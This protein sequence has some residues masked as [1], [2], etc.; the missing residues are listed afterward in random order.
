MS[1]HATRQRVRL[2]ATGLLSLGLVACVAPPAP[3]YQPA[4]D[5]TELLIKQPAHLG[6]GNF[7]AADGV[8]NRSLAVRTSQLTAG[9]TDGTFSTYLHDAIVVELQTSN[10]YDA[11]SGLQLSG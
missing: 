3:K 11:S 7:T 10:Q 6:V 1:T 2:A 8:S 5:N 4:I 9:G